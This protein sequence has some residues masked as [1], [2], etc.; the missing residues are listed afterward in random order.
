MTQLSVTIVGAG[1]AGL[2]A[3]WALLDRG[4]RVTVVEREAV[5]APRAA[6]TDHHRLIRHAYPSTPGYGRR[7]PAAF[8]AWRAI[9]A[10]LE[11]AES[12]WLHD[13]GVLTCSQTAGDHGD[14]AARQMEEAGVDVE[15]LPPDELARRFPH[16]ETANLAYGALSPGGALMCGRILTD[17]SMALRAR[18]AELHE[19]SPVRSVD[20]SGEVRLE[21][22][23][24]WTSDAVLLAAGAEAP[25]LAPRLFPDLFYSR[26]LIVYARPPEDLEEAWEGAPSWSSLDGQGNLWGLTPVEGLPPKLGDGALRRIDPGDHDRRIR[27]EEIQAM[28]RAYQGRFRGIDRFRVSWGQANYWMGAE[29]EEFQLRRD[30]R[31][32]GVSADSGHGF[33]FGALTGED[34]A[35][36]MTGEAALETVRTEM[37]GKAA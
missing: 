26:T 2:C 31:L 20:P 18:G 4:A 10:R 15:R 29:G 7:I 33:K 9:W 14:R 22:G 12:R 11:G 19:R 30:G 6:S 24:A 32:W 25:R 5:P 13:T 1:V 37:A 17:L 35:R 21:D 34:V 36:A 3:A 8:A 27:P 23:R 16:L 28:L